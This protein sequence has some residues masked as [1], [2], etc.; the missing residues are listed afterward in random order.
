MLRP[1]LYLRERRRLHLSVIGLDATGGLDQAAFFDALT[2]G[3][4][5]VVLTHA[6]HVTGRVFDVGP[7]FI[8]ARAMG[9]HTLLDAS[10]TMG[11]IAV[12]P[13]ELAADMVVFSGHKRLRGPSGTGGLY[14][15]PRVALLPTLSRTAKTRCGVLKELR[16]GVPTGFEI[17]RPGRRGLCGIVRGA[18]LE[19]PGGGL[20]CGE[21]AALWPDCCAEA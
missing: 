13:E 19:V 10:Q 5:L 16:A 17:G 21:G 15:D 7:L 18:G 8:A 14:L 4:S 1:L 3:T 11:E 9:A 20:V 6:S 12:R 2:P